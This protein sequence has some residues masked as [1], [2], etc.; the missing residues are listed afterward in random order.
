MLLRQTGFPVGTR[1]RTSTNRSA[2]ITED[3]Q[4]LVSCTI[5]LSLSLS[6]SL[7][8]VERALRALNA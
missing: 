4:L 8:D 6:L 7:S 3:S 2:P 1:W 5:S